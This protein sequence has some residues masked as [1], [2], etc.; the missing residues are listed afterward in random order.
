MN[1][2]LYLPDELGAQTT[3]FP[4]GLLS[5]L[6]REAVERELERRK[7]VATTQ[8]SA[9]YHE[10]DIQGDEGVYTGRILGVEIAE[11]VFHTSDDRVIVYDP[12]SE[13]AYA[14]GDS[15]DREE[16]L[17]AHLADE[18]YIAAMTALGEKPIIDL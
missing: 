18:D 4:R 12:R 14:A 3:D 16:F 10:V 11:N 7:A 5:G 13:R 9:T 2:N 6:L 15:D 8:D 1:I 17:R